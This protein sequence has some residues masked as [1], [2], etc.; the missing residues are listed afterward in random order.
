[1]VTPPVN[2]T[3][4]SQ[5]FDGNMIGAAYTVYNEV[6][7]GWVI[8]ILF[9]VYQFLVYFKTGNATLMWVT[10]FFFV[11]MYATSVWI[12]PY[13]EVLSVQIMFLLLVFEIAGIIYM[14]VMK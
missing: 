5:L 6:M 13:I 14:W 10:G 12:G 3:G 2:A 8:P 11:S 1:M 4:W 9:L 7:P